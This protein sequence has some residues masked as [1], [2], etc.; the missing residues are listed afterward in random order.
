MDQ[1]YGCHGNTGQELIQYLLYWKTRNIRFTFT[2]MSLIGSHG[3]DA[4]LN[5]P[6][7]SLLHHFV[8]ILPLLHRVKVNKETGSAA[9]DRSTICLPIHISTYSKTLDD[10]E[11]TISLNTIM[12]HRSQDMPGNNVLLNHDPTGKLVSPGIYRTLFT[13]REFEWE[14]KYQIGCW[15]AGKKE[16]DR[17]MVQGNRC[18]WALSS[19][20]I[21][22]LAVW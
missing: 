15:L 12:R 7:W 3:L 21:D 9:D 14:E 4:Y 2:Q 8:I 13:P 11:S 10:P 17:T 22:Y 18:Y 20:A 16:K 19:Q 1:T 5:Y 6:F